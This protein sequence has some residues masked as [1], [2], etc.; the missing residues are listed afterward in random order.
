MNNREIKLFIDKKS[1]IDI[2]AKKSLFKYVKYRMIYYRLCFEYSYQETTLENIG[3]EVNCDHA[4]VLNGLNQFDNMYETDKSFK[5]LYD[6]TDKQIR[7]FMPTRFVIMTDNLNNLSDYYLRRKI[8]NLRIINRNAK[9]RI[10]QLKK[11][12]AS[13][14]VKQ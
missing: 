11:L 10:R 14:E 13:I 1:G 12:N 4:L 7:D 3:K 9:H 6:E 8:K 5:K 2:S